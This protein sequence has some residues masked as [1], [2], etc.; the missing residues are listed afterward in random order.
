MSATARAEGTASHWVPSWVGLRAHRRVEKRVAAQ[1]GRKEKR[2]LV[3]SVAE[4]DGPKAGS[5]A[6]SAAGGKDVAVVAD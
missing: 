6:V 1:D 3:Q 4:R 5:W 2:S